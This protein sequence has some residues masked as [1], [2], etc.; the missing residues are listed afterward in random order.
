MTERERTI[1][2]QAKG[3]PLAILAELL[4]ALRE[5]FDTLDF[6]LS[7]LEPRLDDVISQNELDVVER[8]LNE[9]SDQIRQAQ[10]ML[11]A[12]ARTTQ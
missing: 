3:D 2:S 10:K 8:L 4:Q 11:G 6:W 7:K 5:T 1:I 12:E 9:V